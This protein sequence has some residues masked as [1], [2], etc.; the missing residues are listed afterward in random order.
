[1]FPS[2]DSPIR[3][4]LAFPACVLVSA[5]PAPF[6]VSQCE[7]SMEPSLFLSHIMP[8]ACKYYQMLLSFLSPADCLLRFVQ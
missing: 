1:M 7:G 3:K 2:G 5:N 8:P 4:V 6:H